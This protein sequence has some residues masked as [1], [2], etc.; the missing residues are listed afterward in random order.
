MGGPISP[1][2][3]VISTR[4]LR[5]VLIFEPKDL[6]ISVEAGMPYAEFESLLASH[7]MM[8]PLDPPYRAESTVGG[9]V[10]AN[11]SGP[12]RRL[13]GTARDLVIGMRF[14]TL[15]GQIIQSGGMVVKNVAGLDMAKLLIGSWGTL[16][17]IVSVNFKLIPAPPAERTFQLTGTLEEVFAARDAILRGVLLPSA[18]DILNPA[19]AATAIGEQRWTLLV[20]AGGNPAVLDR[21]QRELGAFTVFDPNR[22]TAVEEFTP[23]YLAGGESRWVRTVSATLTDLAAR[24]ASHDGPVVA[25]AANGVAYLHGDGPAP[26]AWPHPGSA[27]PVM[28]KVKD[29]L[30]P[31]HLLNPGRLYGRI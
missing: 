31:K 17:A 16:A 12:R 11:L 15:E 6:T 30:D 8:V 24:I 7:G 29:M 20:R 23:R 22:W 26:E 5:R 19:A 13:Y 10:A 1:T 9:V 27:F 2:Q 18:V 4:N 3:T 25:R 21:Y 14:A 28:M